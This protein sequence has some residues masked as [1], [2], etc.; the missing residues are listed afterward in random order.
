M[1]RQPLSRWQTVSLVAVPVAWAV[2]LLFHPTG[3]NDAFY[4]VVR[5][6]VVAWQVVHIGMLLFIPLMAG[7]VYL[8]LRG[9]DGRAAQVARMALVPFVVFYAAFEILVGIGTGI[10]VNDVNGLAAAEQATGAKLAEALGQS[11]IPAAFSVVG[12]LAW[13]VAMVAAALALHRRA[14]APVAVAVLLVLSAVPVV[15]HEPPFGP[16]G[17]ALFAASVL[18][19]GRTPAQRATAAVAVPVPP[20]APSHSRP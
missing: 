9:V 2:L 19:L 1:E 12:G 16:A 10:V 7:V 3:D 8:L 11:A 15:I 13:C 18:I 4:P 6:N 20:L 5:D 14:G 17:L